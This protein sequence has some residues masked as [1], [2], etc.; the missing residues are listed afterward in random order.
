MRARGF[1]FLA[2]LLLA[3][4]ALH[5]SAQTPE[6]KPAEQA[7]AA[8]EEP[9]EPEEEDFSKPMGPA[10]PF[11]RG[12]PRGS[13][14][15]FIVAT[16]AG[17]YE[18]AAEFLDLRRLPPEQKETG[19][20]LARQFKA[21]LDRTLWVDFTTLSDTN[22]GLGDDGLPS[23]QD[24][25]GEIETEAGPL[26]LLLQRV[27]R[28]GDGVRIWKVS[29]VTVGQVPELYLEFGPG[30][31][32]ELLPGFLFEYSVLGLDLWQWLGMALLLLSG[33]AI[34]LLLAGTLIRLLGVLL[35]RGEG[36]LD[37]R[38]VRVVRGP[39]RMALTIFVFAVG[40][41]YLALDVP[42][43]DFLRALERVLWVVSFA[44]LTFRLLDI[45]ALALRAQAE[46][47][48]N[49]AL[50]PVLSPMQ[51]IAK[52]LV[53]LFGGLGVLGTLGVNI[54]AAV[55]G[56]GVGGIAVAL[57]AQKTIENLIGGINLFADRPVKVG[58]FFRYGDQ[59]G[60]VEEI[61]LRSTR[62]RSLDRTVVS[63]PNAAFSDLPLENFTTRERMRLFT[64]IGLRYETTPDQLCYVLARLR[65]VLLEHPRVLPDPARVRFVGFGAY[66]LD[67]EVFAYVDTPD[68]SEFLAIREDIFLQ[69]MRVV[70]E[71]GTGF[72]FPSS[73]TYVGRDEGLSEEEQRAAEQ[74]VAAWREKGELPFPA[75]PEEFRRKKENTGAWPP[76]GSPGAAE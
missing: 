37:P 52:V 7:Q 51:R 39:V 43:Q 57:A 21:V 10:D 28:E 58:D 33:W 41:R 15:G 48:G 60:T 50:V 12:T 49:L 27:P 34:S 4:A 32:E 19:P 75:F 14:Y 68:W 13:M 53:V 11:N 47:R 64:V 66:S 20:Q 72:A 22:A 61:G 16:R 69:F 24:R 25:L 42:V 71:A 44:W 30:W 5:A 23:W 62:I 74:R 29:A 63:I 38:V 35:R 76:P 36:G 8:T 73:T 18:R 3:T 45:G 67:L 56:L 59:V 54:T 9:A 40:R 6:A 1:A 17:E 2:H 26:S 55:A 31:L 46:R 65:Q 70:A